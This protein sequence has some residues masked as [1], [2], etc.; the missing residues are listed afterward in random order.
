MAS[1]SKFIGA[2][3]EG[4]IF[5]PCGWFPNNLVNVFNHVSDDIVKFYW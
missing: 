3:C 2:K 4:L 1:I 5:R